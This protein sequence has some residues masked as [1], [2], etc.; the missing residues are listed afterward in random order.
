MGGIDVTSF[1]LRVPLDRGRGSETDASAPRDR[2]EAAE[3]AGPLEIAKRRHAPALYVV[4]EQYNVVLSRSAPA[5]SIAPSLTVENGRLPA[6]V[7][8]VVRSL[9]ASH[10]DADAEPLI[11]LLNPRVLLRVVPLEGMTGRHHAVILERYEARAGLSTAAERFG[12]SPREMEVLRHLVKG[13]STSEIAAALHIAET[14]VQDHVKRLSG[15][16]S[17]RKRTEIVARAL[18][19]R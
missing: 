15:K 12:L 2:Q 13:D 16:M 17:A 4:D 1:A 6:Q 19:S 18:G 3:A 5:A 9:V 14:T 11:A 7:E 8:S 10:D